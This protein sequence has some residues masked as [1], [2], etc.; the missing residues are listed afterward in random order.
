[1][2]NTCAKCGAQN[3]PL[4]KFCRGCGQPVSGAAPVAAAG[5]S[6]SQKMC[7]NGHFYDGPQCPYC[8][9]QAAATPFG[10]PGAVPQTVAEGGVA[11]GGGAGAIPKGRTVVEGGGPGV[12]IP[13]R[14]PGGTVVE[15]E[16]SRR[17]VGWLVV[18]NSAEETSY[19]D[20]RVH[21]GKNLIGRIGQ[22]VDVAINDKRISSQHALLVHKEGAYRLTDM[23][24]GNGTIINGEEADTVQLQD[25]DRIKLGRTTLV[26]RTFQDLAE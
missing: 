11:G 24:S 13:A 14:R 20:F 4:A 1:M 16:V 26:F 12:G 17:L 2:M 15:T 19:K 3:N 9:A 21:D 6:P 25:G 10:Q 23:G 7:T 8:P 22:R 5:G 18:M